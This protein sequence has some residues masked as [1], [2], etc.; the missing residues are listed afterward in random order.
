MFPFSNIVILT[1][2]FPDILFL[3]FLQTVL[4][5][6][7]MLHGEG[8]LG[9]YSIPTLKIQDVSKWQSGLNRL[10][11][12]S[13]LN[14]YMPYMCIEGGRQWDL[15][16]KMPSSDYEMVPYWYRK[17]EDI[18]SGGKMWSNV[19]LCCLFPSAHV[20]LDRTNFPLYMDNHG[21]CYII[22][23]VSLLFRPL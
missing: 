21:H 20:T 18:L 10:C 4:M 9:P 6:S 5:T 11:T 15:Q 22:T 7:P 17:G 8:F 1:S 12:T 3:T 23:F 2:P 13:W 14:I 19:A 16:M